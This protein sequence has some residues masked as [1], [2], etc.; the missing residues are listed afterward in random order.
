MSRNEDKAKGT[1]KTINF[2]FNIGERK[3]KDDLLEKN[4][5]IKEII[6]TNESSKLKTEEDKN[7]DIK[8]EEDKLKEIEEKCK[9]I[10]KELPLL[11]YFKMFDDE[12]IK[13]FQKGN[14]LELFAEIVDAIRNHE[15]DKNESSI[16]ELFEKGINEDILYYTFNKDAIRIYMDLYKFYNKFKEYNVLEDT[17]INEFEKEENLKSFD[18]IYRNMKINLFKKTGGT[19][20]FSEMFFINIDIKIIHFFIRVYMIR[21]FINLKNNEKRN[22]FSIINQKDHLNRIL[23]LKTIDEILCKKFIYDRLEDNDLD[24]KKNYENNF[25]SFFE[26]MLDLIFFESIFTRDEGKKIIIIIKIFL[27]NIIVFIMNYLC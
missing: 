2:K 13:F 16:I 23:I 15:V 17:F 10:F 22:F 20:L 11:Y 27:K 5:D 25:F 21:I 6:N 9:L 1:E 18:N 14:N 12:F 26:M 24:E 19:E 4:K 8:E 7:Q 3:S